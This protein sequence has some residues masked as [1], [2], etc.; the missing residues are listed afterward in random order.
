MSLDYYQILHL[1]PTATSAEIKTAYRRMAKLFHPDKNPG[2]EEKFKEVKE[3]YETLIDI[4]KRSRYDSKRNYTIS[5][6]AKKTEPVKKPKTY[7]F[8]EQEVKH[9]QYYQEHY[10]S[11]VY[12]KPKQADTKPNYKELTYILISIPAAVA[13]L[14]LLVNLYQKPATGK[15]KSV[16]EKIVS[17]IKTSDS[18]YKAS[19]GPAVFDTLSKPFIK[20]INQSGHDAI[21]FL[22]NDNNKT[23]R[24]HFIAH[25][26]Q[27]YL[28][29]IPK[30][31][32]NL[33][34]WTGEGFTNKRYLFNTRIGNFTE[35]LNIDSFTH[36]INIVPAQQDSFLF[37]IPATKTSIADTL[38]LKRIFTTN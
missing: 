24:H 20:I 36:K 38:L 18:P 1:K 12:T 26:Y 8:T 22:K 11:K 19:F 31:S 10:K 21:V 15:T 25:N 4:S 33:Y 35:T 23:I 34:Y 3:A 16:S 30:G 17:E 28:E 32:Y 9:R 2:A 27:L 7:T 5:T 6:Q 37:S 29:K 14:L 13:L